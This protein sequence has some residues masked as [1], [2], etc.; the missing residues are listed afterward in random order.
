MPDH[1]SGGGLR[2]WPRWVGYVLA[3]GGAA[4]AFA[5]THLLPPLLH[6][7]PFAVFF[8]FS[9]ILTLWAGPGPGFTLVGLTVLA[10]TLLLQP[11]VGPIGT[12]GFLVVALPTIAFIHRH[13]RSVAALRES[14]RRY[15]YLSDL[16]SDVV[17]YDDLEGRI[18]SINP[19]ASTLTGYPLEAI[20]GRKTLDFAMPGCLDRALRARQALLAPDGPKTVALELDFRGV[21]GRIITFD[22]R[23]G[24]HVV[25][26]RP[27]G[28]RT[29]ARD[30]SDRR[31]LEAQLRQG[32][33]MEAIGRLAGGVAHD[34]NN[35][36]TV[37]MG[38]LEI[39]LVRLGPSH[40]QS[41]GLRQSLLACERAAQLVHQLLAFGRK[42]ALQPVVLDPNG[43]V[44]GLDSMLRHLIGAH[45]SLKTDL[46]PDVGR[47]TADPTQL[48]QVLMNLALNARDA[49]PHGGTITV[50]TANTE[51]P[52]GQ[53]HAGAHVEP[54]RY[55]VIAV[56]DTGQGMDAETQAHIF[57]P[58]FT[59]K[60]EGKGTGLGLATVYGIVKQSGGYIWVDTAIGRGTPIRDLP[61][62]RRRA[63]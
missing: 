13:Q 17:V 34:F 25:D 32:L 35:L 63:P 56:T 16:S 52:E 54:G 45:V 21:D 15:Q 2:A 20:L 22:T 11:P 18:E 41:E 4:V 39:A 47:I 23:S 42:Q 60:A 33:K 28:F 6:R 27:V 59:T 61:A 38:Y 31:R 10:T 57:E 30:I 14:E 37:V 62:T 29:V 24:V 48:T 53:I 19:T 7:T 40:A 44:R 5:L 1:R 46:D 49:M 26:G 50:G 3:V 55:V 58:F 9:G 36:L 12:I 43:V 51:V 8:V